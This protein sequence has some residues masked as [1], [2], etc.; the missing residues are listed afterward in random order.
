MRA[1]GLVFAAISLLLLANPAAANGGKHKHHHPPKNLVVHPGESIQAAVDAASS[2]DTIVVLPG[3][4]HEAGVPCPTDASHTCAV[5][6][7]KPNISLVGAGK[8]DAG[9]VL[10]NAGGQDQGIAFAPPAANGATCLNDVAQ[11][12]AGPSVTGFTVNGFG[13]EGIFLFC[14]DRF[15]VRFNET[16]DNVEYGIFPSHS[17][18]GS[19]SFNLATGSNDTGVYIG[20]SSDV[21]VDHNLARG[22]VSGFEIENCHDVRLD[23]NV[24]TGN[25][26]GI[27]SF[28]LPFLDVNQNT[29][30]R[31]DHNWVQGNNKPNTCVDPTDAV[32]G[33]PQGTGILA[34]AVDANRVDHNVVLNNDS[35]GIAV[36]NFCVAQGLDDATC[37]R[38]GIE[39]NS[40]GN[41]ID[42]NAAFG[43][44]KNPS[45]LIRSVFAVDLAWDGT[46]TGNCWSK[47]ASGTQFPAELP[48]CQ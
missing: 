16:N 36:A 42:H 44:G 25:T 18:N 5:V 24:A 34:L 12:L 39:P 6:V 46:G 1:S 15:T 19:V 2:G 10:E 17:T 40:D 22:N 28:T 20:Q 26:G 37:G 38:L 11:R 31:I 30:N 33:V 48:P 7:T 13:G 3:T 43:N 23:H 41:Q 9:V 32:C 27:L 8:H 29:G 21:H 14:V 45:D 4:Y 35:Y 47:N